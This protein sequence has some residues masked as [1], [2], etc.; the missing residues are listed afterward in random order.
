MPARTEP[1]SK[2]ALFSGATA[3]AKHETYQR[4]LR[5]SR[6]DP[7]SSAR[8]GAIATGLAPAGEVVVFDASNPRPSAK[9]VRTRVVLDKG[10]E[11]ADVDI[12]ARSDDEWLVAYCTDYEVSVAVVPADRAAKARAPYLLHGTP[13]PDVFA[14]K[15]RPSFRA[16]RFLTPRL[17]LVAANRPGRA[18]AELLLIDVPAEPISGAV[19]LKKSLPRSALG[20]AALAVSSLA[21]PLPDS[22]MQH[23]VAVATQDKALQLFTLDHDPAGRP[24]RGPLR[25]FLRLP[26]AHAFPATA[27]ALSPHHCPRDRRTA[28]PQYLKLASA[29][30]AGRVLVHT[31]PLA[32]FPAD[33]SQHTA[34]QPTRYALRPLGR[35]AEAAGNALGLFMAFVV[36]ALGAL[37][38]QAYVELRGGTAEIVGAKAWLPRR[39]TDWIGQDYMFADGLPKGV[40]DARRT[41]GI[42][43]EQRM[44]REGAVRLRDA[45]DWRRAKVSGDAAKEKAEE[46]PKAVLITQGEGNKLSADMVDKE[47]AES[48]AARPWEELDAAEQRTWRAKLLDAGV[49]AVEEGEN[50]LKGEFLRLGPA[51]AGTC[52]DDSCRRLFWRA[53]RRRGWRRAV[54]VVWGALDAFSKLR[55]IGSTRCGIARASVGCR[56]RSARESLAFA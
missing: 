15:A 46:R 13:H 39:L 6:A 11:A 25:P 22:P 41:Y 30:P 36:V 53:R 31:F 18:G 24:P 34:A 32:P 40:R 17:L 28:P 47:H 21:S 50:V 33:P 7:E 26:A 54:M 44:V 43:R 42:E 29:S 52:S 49:W 27:L 2:A 12:V 14:S 19:V 48:R 3:S 10:Q 55:N 1:L 20:I 8:L 37:L 5:L 51:D 9:D 23:V 35:R 16:L 4:L 56:W 38:L 45:L